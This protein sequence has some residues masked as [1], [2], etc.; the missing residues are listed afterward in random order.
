MPEIHV[1]LE[2]PEAIE[3]KKSLLSC[4]LGLLEIIR[5]IRKYQFLRKKELSEKLKLKT[6]FSKLKTDMNQMLKSLPKHKNIQSPDNTTSSRTRKRKI[7]EDFSP[8]LESELQTI[9]EKLA[10]LS[11]E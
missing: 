11:S 4:E 3:A 5:K 6:S 8:D 7:S 9:R 1:R 2:Y 10:K